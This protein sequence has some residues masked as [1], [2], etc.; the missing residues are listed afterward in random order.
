MAT[1]ATALGANRLVRAPARPAR[2]MTIRVQD[3]R[4]GGRPVPGSGVTWVVSRVNSRSFYVRSGGQQA[5]HPVATW[6]AWLQDRFTEGVVFLDE[7]PVQPPDGARRHYG[8]NVCPRHRDLRILRAANEVLGGY[9]ITECVE[10]D[11]V[12]RFVVL[13]GDKK[14]AYD[15]VVHPDWYLPPSCTCPDAR[16]ILLRRDGSSCKHIIAVLLRTEEL[17]YQLLDLF[18]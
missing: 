1:T 17:R 15:V 9:R 5:R 11:G 13:R 8:A 6:S 16:S 3:V 14:R 10:K 12:R 2:G 7:S 4:H 18:L